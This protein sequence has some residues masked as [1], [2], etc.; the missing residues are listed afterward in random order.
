[1]YG[2]EDFANFC[3]KKRKFKTISTVINFDMVGRMDPELKRL[4]YMCSD[5]LSEKFSKA[6]QLSTNLDLREKDQEKM[7]QLDTRSF[8]MKGID[9]VNLSTGSHIDYHAASDDE[10]YINYI[11]MVNVFNFV[12]ALIQNW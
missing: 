3:L 5:S 11:G 1:L 6:V 2:S 4:F 8:Y 9:C 12:H 10:R 7:L